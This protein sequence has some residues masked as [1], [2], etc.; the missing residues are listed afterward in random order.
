NRRADASRAASDQGLAACQ[1]LFTHRILLPLWFAFVLARRCPRSAARRTLLVV[2]PLS[3]TLPAERDERRWRGRLLPPCAQL[4]P[5]AIRGNLTLAQEYLDDC[6]K[7]IHLS[8]KPL[9][10]RPEDDFAWRFRALLLPR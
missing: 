9:T 6:P 5:A 10:A 4:L 1:T 7:S 8:S 2:G 3:R